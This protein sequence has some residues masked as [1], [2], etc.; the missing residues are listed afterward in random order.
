MNLVMSDKNLNNN[1]K[2][3]IKPY[4]LV[5]VLILILI[6]ILIYC[7][8]VGLK[9]VIAIVFKVEYRYGL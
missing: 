7:F 3:L 5:L 6:L 8:F 1:N 9:R 4:D 2:N